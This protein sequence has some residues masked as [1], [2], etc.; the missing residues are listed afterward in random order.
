M[1]PLSIGQNQLLDVVELSPPCFVAAEKQYGYVLVLETSEEATRLRR[2]EED[3]CKGHNF[4]LPVINGQVLN[5]EFTGFLRCV[6][7]SRMSLIKLGNQATLLTNTNFIIN[8]QYINT[9]VY[10]FKK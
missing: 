1:K 4:F 5:F 2:V 9:A 8:K 3:V 7:F 6:S 10:S